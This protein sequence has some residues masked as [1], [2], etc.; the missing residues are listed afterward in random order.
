M[1]YFCRRKSYNQIVEQILGPHFISSYVIIMV[2]SS[3]SVEKAP[4]TSREVWIW[5][6][7]LQ[8]VETG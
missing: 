4:I 1:S 7:T 6:L 3:G 5:D 2:T 8:W